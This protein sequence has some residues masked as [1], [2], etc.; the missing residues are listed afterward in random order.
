MSFISRSDLPTTLLQI[1]DVRL[2]LSQPG[3]VQL[4]SMVSLALG[5]ATFLTAG[6]VPSD[7]LNAVQQML[8]ILSETFP[9]EVTNRL[10]LDWPNSLI[11]I[12]GSKYDPIIIS[13]LGHILQMCAS[14]S[15]TL[16][17]EVHGSCLQMSLK[18]LWYYANVYHQLDTS[19]PLPPYFLN[20]L[21]MP[22]ITN[23]IQQEGD[24]TSCVIGYC[25]EALVV[26]KLAA[27]FNSGGIHVSDRELACLSSM[28]GIESHVV[29][30]W[31]R[32]PGAI[33]HMCLFFLMLS[34]GGALNTLILP[35]LTPAPMSTMASYIT[36]ILTMSPYSTPTVMPTMTSYTNPMSTMSPYSAATLFPTRIPDP[37]TM[38]TRLPYPIPPPAMSTQPTPIPAMYS[39]STPIPTMYSYSTPY[40]TVFPPPMSTN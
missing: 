8:N 34:G 33:E 27:D 26:T 31:L 36:P 20:V 18:S 13:H 28:I 35:G 24:L 5:D 40:P 37:T 1:R 15:S 29:E 2:C 21:A 25:F 14:G 6:A 30:I 32:I 7:V 19:K 23:Y 38:P 11:N 9:A 16:T 17:D 3:I 22:E 10:P 39:Y 12:S 4:A